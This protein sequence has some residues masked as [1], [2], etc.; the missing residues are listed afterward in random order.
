MI[1]NY[2]QMDNDLQRKKETLFH[3]ENI[4]KHLKGNITVGDWYMAQDSNII[5]VTLNPWELHTFR[6]EMHRAL[7][8]WQDK[9]R[10]V[11]NIFGDELRVYYH[12]PHWPIG[13]TVRENA[14]TINL[15]D[16]GMPD[17]HLA[18]HEPEFICQDKWTVSCPMEGENGE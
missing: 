9:V 4:L 3:M 17:C 2:E 13:M 15:S 12:V 16:Y 7:G 10:E 11:V 1:F 18:E 14:K 8:G 5:R 6:Q